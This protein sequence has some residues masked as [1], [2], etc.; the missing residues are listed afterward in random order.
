ME[1]R[2]LNNK[3]LKAFIIAFINKKEKES[4]NINYIEYSYYELK[5]KYGLTEEQIDE[6]LR[7]SRDYFENKNYDVYFTNAEFQYNG[8]KRK[9]ETNDYMVAVKYK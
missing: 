8:Q 7:V 9:V 6:V 2:I 5:V 3:E 1:V 4:S